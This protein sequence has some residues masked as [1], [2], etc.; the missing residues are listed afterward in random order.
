MQRRDFLVSS[1][2]LP[3]VGAAPARAFEP[4]FGSAAEAAAAIRARKISALELTQAV[5]KQLDTHNPKLNAVIQRFDEKSLERAKAADAALARKQFWG[6][7]HGVPITIKECFAY[8]STPTSAGVPARKDF[9]PKKNALA[10]DRL[11][12]AGAIILGKTNIPVALDDWQSDSP[13]YGVSNNP[14]DLTRTP[15]GSTGGGAAAL[16]AGMGFLTLGSDAGG[17]IRLPTH[18]CGVYG[19][20]PSLELISGRGHVPPF[21]D[22]ALQYFMDLGVVGP[23]ARSAGDLRLALEV[24]GGPAPE[25]AKA[26]KWT[27]PAPRHKTLKQYRIG[28]P[29]DDSFCPVSPDVKAVLDAAPAEL[30]RAGCKIHR[31]WPEGIVPQE[32][33]ATYMYQLGSWSSASLSDKAT[34]DLRAAWQKDP[35][36]PWLASAFEPHK[37]WRAATERRLAARAAWERYFRTQDVFLIPTAFS[38]A[39][40]HDHSQPQEARTLMTPAGKRTYWDLINWVSFAT[41]AG[42]PA[43]VAPVGRTTAGLPVGIQILG[44]W[45]EDSSPIEFAALMEP[46]TGGFQ[47]PKGY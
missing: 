27:M 4:P 33:L 22:G 7:L 25:D 13:N 36:N 1:F 9:R 5:L 38:A 19:L 45:M 2:A 20:K 16:A 39:F 31:G 42:I 35:K 47:A 28:L 30:E 14:W 24:L 23:L 3:L 41:L 6:P 15:G 34:A 46:V 44:P 26:W 8:D 21:T 40:L 32:Q 17:S 12:Q 10:V 18:F 11:L 29:P 43:T 37:H